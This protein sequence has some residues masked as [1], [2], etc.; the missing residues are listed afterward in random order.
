MIK[1]NSNET[2]K[3]IDDKN[4]IDMNENGDKNLVNERKTHFDNYTKKKLKN[5]KLT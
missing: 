5:I 3:Q 4:N 1:L 2:T